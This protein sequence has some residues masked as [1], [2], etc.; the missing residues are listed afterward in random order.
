MLFGPRALVSA[1]FQALLLPADRNVCVRAIGI[2]AEARRM[3]RQGEEELHRILHSD[4]DGVAGDMRSGK[5][6]HVE[7]PPRMIRYGAPERFA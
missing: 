6:R 3:I 5:W 7:L 4:G 1:L 2:N